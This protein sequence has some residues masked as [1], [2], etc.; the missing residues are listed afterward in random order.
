MIKIG[1]YLFRRSHR[2]GKKYDVFRASNEEYITS[3]GSSLHQQ[4]KDKIGLWSNL[5][6]KDKERRKRYYDRHGKYATFESA[7]W[8]SHRFLW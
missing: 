7:K 6:H 5:D 8:F 4:Y 1:N 3:F 2:F